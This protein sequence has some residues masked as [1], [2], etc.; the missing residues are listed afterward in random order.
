MGALFHLA[1]KYLQV[2]FLLKCPSHVFPHLP[3]S[4]L[5]F[6]LSPGHGLARSFFG[7]ADVLSPMG[8]HHN[9]HHLMRLRQLEQLLIFFMD[10]PFHKVIS[11]TPF[12]L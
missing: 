8:Y 5:V 7:E 4:S 9:T 10:L 11:V 3:M 12:S 6:L 2:R 1:S